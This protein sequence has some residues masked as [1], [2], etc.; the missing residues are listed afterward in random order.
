MIAGLPGGLS[1][2]DSRHQK[3]CILFDGATDG[4]SEH[5]VAT[6]TPEP[7]T[8]PDSRRRV[9]EVPKRSGRLPFDN[10]LRSQGLESLRRLVASR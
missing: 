1:P 3:V 8:P 4:F 7:I 2:R 9:A 10:T 5:G 6:G